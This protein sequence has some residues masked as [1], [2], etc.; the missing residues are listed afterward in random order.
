VLTK[1]P[2]RAVNINWTREDVMTVDCANTPARPMIGSPLGGEI[3]S[4]TVIARRDKPDIGIVLAETAA[5]ERFLASSTEPAITGSM[6]DNS[7]VGRGIDVWSRDDRQVFSF[8][9]K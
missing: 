9:A 3:I 6:Q 7:P 4:Y 8:Q 5:G 1:E 2:A